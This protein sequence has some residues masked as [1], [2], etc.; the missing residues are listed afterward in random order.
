[1]LKYCCG[2]LFYLI[3]SEI[4]TFEGFSNLMCLALELFQGVEAFWTLAIITDCIYS[5]KVTFDFDTS[6]LR[7]AYSRFQASFLCSFAP[8][9]SNYFK[10][11]ESWAETGFCQ[12][13][14]WLYQAWNSCCISLLP[15]C[16]ALCQSGGL[17]S[18]YSS[19]SCCAYPPLRR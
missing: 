19:N 14:C 5:S 10:S 16:I 3:D 4:S 2:A 17:A 1:M 13:Y 6:N 12:G 8:V 15:T 18:I 11:W 7:G 9:W